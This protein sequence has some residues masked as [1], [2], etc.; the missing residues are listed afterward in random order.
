MAE[1]HLR[2]NRY[3][4]DYQKEIRRAQ[5]QFL[6]WTGQ[7]GLFALEAITKTDIFAYQEFLLGQRSKLTGQPLTPGVLATRYGAVKL[8]FSLLYRAGYLKTN[9]THGINFELPCHTSARRAFSRG[10]ISGL[11]S[12]IDPN[13]NPRDRALFELMYSSGLRVCEAARLLVK[14]LSLERR[15]IIV[16]GKFGRDRLVPLSR[17]AEAFLRHYLGKRA[18]NLEEPVFLS[19]YSR[20][21]KKGLLPE[22]ISRRFRDILKKLDMDKKETSTHSIRH[23]TATHLLDNGAGIRHVQELL[24]HRNPETP[25]RYTH[26]QTDGLFKIY[27]KYHPREHELFE[28][29]DEAYAGRVKKLLADQGGMLIE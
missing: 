2:G 28:V 19:M 16:R 29:V 27:R 1:A 7:N 21:A 17:V 3:C 18:A 20:H 5:E 22:S 10:E 12:R 6:L 26:V 9:V 23:S 13:A 24:G 15:E 14:D 11:L 8:L 25:A 4:G